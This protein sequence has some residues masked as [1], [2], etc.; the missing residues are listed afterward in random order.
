MLDVSEQLPCKLPACTRHPNPSFPEANQK[1][2]GTLHRAYEVVSERCGEELRKPTR[3]TA[4]IN[5]GIRRCVRRILL[6]FNANDCL[7][8]S[9]RINYLALVLDHVLQD[10]YRMGSLAYLPAPL[11]L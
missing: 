11:M 6:I 1:A 9:Q 7:G 10:A 4:G 2:R 3:S 8:G 5:E